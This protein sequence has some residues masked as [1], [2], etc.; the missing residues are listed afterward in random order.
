MAPEI[1][2]RGPIVP[3]GAPSLELSKPKIMPSSSY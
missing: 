3:P 2:K 1:T